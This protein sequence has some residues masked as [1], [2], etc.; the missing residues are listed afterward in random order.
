[1]IAM[2]NVRELVSDD[3]IDQ[4]WRDLHE[5]SVENQ[6]MGRRD[7]RTPAHLYRPDEKF[8]PLLYLLAENWQASFERGR[9]VLS[10][11]LHIPSDQAVADTI[12]F[13]R[14][15]GTDDYAR[16]FAHY[17]Y[18]V[19]IHPQ[20]ILLAEMKKCLT[21]LELSRSSLNTPSREL[22]LLVEDPTSF[23]PNATFDV[24]EIR[25]FGCADHNRLIGRNRD[26]HGLSLRATQLETYQF[27]TNLDCVLFH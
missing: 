14:S 7:V 21:W 3:V 24:G 4:R 1:M 19:W 6:R 8:W 27:P 25:L 15:D 2:S 12:G 16:P 18:P 26:S 9:Q 17:T 11:L 5:R 23:F 13:V 20:P 10:S 22:G